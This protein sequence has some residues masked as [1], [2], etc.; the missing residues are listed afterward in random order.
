MQI[1]CTVEIIDVS[2]Y[3]TSKQLLSCAQICLSSK[4]D[5]FEVE[6]VEYVEYYENSIAFKGG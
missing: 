5:F 6:Y 1:L 2:L 3:Y 4:H